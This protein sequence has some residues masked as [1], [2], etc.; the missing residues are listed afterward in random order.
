[1]R[2]E[3]LQM[4][5]H[6][7]RTVPI[8]YNLAEK[9]G[10][11]YEKASFEELPIVDKSHYIQSGMSILSSKFIKDY[12]NGRLIWLRTSG[13]TGK[14]T[15][16]YW[17]K[18]EYDKSLL[19]LWLLRKRYYGITP[20]D[21]LCYFYAADLPGMEKVVT[22][23]HY[24]AIS[25]ECLFDGCLTEVYGQLLE[26]NPKWM[27]L[28]PSV[29]LLLCEEAV[30]HG[31]PSALRY[32][33]LT[34]EYLE[35]GVEKKIQDT[36]SC[37][38]ANQYGSKEVNSIAYAC[39]EGK[40]HVMSDNVYVEMTDGLYGEEICVTSLQN[41]VMPLVRFN[42]EDRGR[43]YKNV[44]CSCGRCG[45]ILE[46]EAGRSNDWILLKNG[47]KLHAYALM[48]IVQQLN[49]SLEGMILQYQI[50]QKE[51]DAFLV[52]LVLE[53][54]GVEKEICEV[55]QERFSKRLQ[56]LVQL[57]VE[58]MTKLLPAH[59]TGKLACFMSCME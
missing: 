7:Y 24:M 33:E 58:Y 5:R 51:Y 12:I 16:I 28:Q 44:F 6:A 49:Y 42:M 8:Y 41:H 19:T 43:L 47:E 48:Q 20:L 34:G 37:Q 2:E 46:L 56:Y 15:E 52:R 50:V 27:I 40:L 18:T 29:A 59:Q 21:R 30:H 13:S 25:R 26:Y 38:T 23:K 4:A 1:M 55:L 31:V 54:K 39:P 17:K 57:T 10:L 32:I 11:D 9:I 3:I 45:D 35:A 14:S 53:G 36:F 22:E